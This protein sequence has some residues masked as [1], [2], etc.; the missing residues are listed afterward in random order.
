M[1]KSF[2][3]YRF[4]LYFT[5]TI[6]STFGCGFKLLEPQFQICS[7]PF[8]VKLTVLRKMASGVGGTHCDKIVKPNYAEVRTP[9]FYRFF[10]TLKIFVVT[11][12]N[13]CI[14]A[15][16]IIAMF[17][18]TSSMNTNVD[19]CVQLTVKHFKAPLKLVCN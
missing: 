18:S 7:T 8:P 17:G 13:S 14:G 16:R 10:F 3:M 1:S 5:L 12:C 2:K 15:T 9:D 6:I 19:N 4:V 11:S